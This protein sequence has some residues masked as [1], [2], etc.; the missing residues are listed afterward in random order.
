MDVPLVKR[1]EEFNPLYGKPPSERTMQELIELGYVIIDKPCGPSSHEVTGW[2]KI[3]AGAPKS[4][5]AGTLDP[6]V[7]GVL[8]VAFS[9]ATAALALLIESRKEYVCIIRFHKSVPRQKIEQAFRDFTGKIT[10]TPPLRSA[11]ARRPRERK[12]YYIDILQYK[13][14][15]VLFRVGCEAGT[16]VRKLCFDVG[17]A[18]GVGANMLELRRT[19][20]G[21]I[22]EEKAVTLQDL[23]D[24]AWLWRTHGDES[25]LRSLLLPVEEA[26]R[27]KRIWIRDSAV[28]ALCRGAALAAPGVSRL[29]PGILPGERV[30]VLSLKHELVS[31]SEAKSSSSE[32]MNMQK[33]IVATPVRVIMK[34]GVYP[35]GW[36]QKN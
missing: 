13:D 15:D 23:S 14:K 6:N 18:L 10:Q 19:R 16:Y 26:V 4:G 33:G 22:P 24:A 28:E 25:L 7:S 8:P 32:I 5:H 35:K 20:V 27:L 36:G 21:H 30:A 34:S 11:V 3:I 29:D 31:I 17:K 9:R 1:E 2:T 12:V